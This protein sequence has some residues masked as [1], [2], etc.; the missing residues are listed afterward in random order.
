VANGLQEQELP[1]RWSAKRKMEIVL[2]LLRDEDLG[3]LRG[4]AVIAAFVERYNHQWLVDRHGYRTPAAGR[5]QFSSL[6]P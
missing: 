4:A 5:R 2:R 3:Q 6:A 1:E